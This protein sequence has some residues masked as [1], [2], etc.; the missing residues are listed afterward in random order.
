MEEIPN[1]HL[2]KDKWWHVYYQL[3]TGDRRISEPS[4]VSSLHYLSFV[5]QALL[6][7]PGVSW[8]AFLFWSQLKRQRYMASRNAYGATILV[9]CRCFS[10]SHFLVPCF[11]SGGYINQPPEHFGEGEVIYDVGIRKGGEVGNSWYAHLRWPQF[12]CETK[13]YLLISFSTLCRSPFC[14]RFQP[15]SQLFDT[16]SS[17]F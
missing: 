14:G 4:T 2:E 8:R 10:F 9:V 3:T 11:F 15:V 12:I 6:G 7:F 16:S 17:R 1:N 5:V 13:S